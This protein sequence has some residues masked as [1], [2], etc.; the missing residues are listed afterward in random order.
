[1]CRE[2]GTEHG[3]IFHSLL[4]ELFWRG[5][6]GAEVCGVRVASALPLLNALSPVGEAAFILGAWGEEAHA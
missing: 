3:P 2:P 5:D 4:A 1:M 6:V